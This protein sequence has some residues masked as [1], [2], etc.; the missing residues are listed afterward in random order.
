MLVAGVSSLQ[1]VCQQSVSLDAERRFATKLFAHLQ[2][3][4][5]AYHLE[6]HAGELIQ[7]LSRGSGATGT[8]ISTLWFSIIPTLFEAVVVGTVFWKVLGTPSIAITTVTSVALYLVYTVKMTN[9]R[10]EQ[11]RKVIESSETVGRIETES[12]VNY[13]TIVMFGKE[14]GEVERYGTVRKEYKNERVDMLGLFACIQLGQQSIRLA[15]T[16]IGL[17]LAGRAAVYGAGGGG[18]DFLSAGS[19]VVVQLYIQQLFTP[20]SI[21]GFMYRQLSEALT[22]L[23]KAI[24]VLKSK[25]IVMDAKGALDWDTALKQKQR[26]SSDKVAANNTNIGWFSA[27]RDENNPLRGGITFDNVTFKYQVVAPS[28]KLGGP[29]KRKEYVGKGFRGRGCAMW[30]GS[31]AGMGANFWIKSAKSSKESDGMNRKEDKKLDVGGIENVSFHIPAGKTA[32]LVGPSE[33]ANA[34]RRFVN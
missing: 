1:N 34:F 20:L 3:L 25:P 10:L 17:W 24:D 28:K 11:R 5:A 6:R 31:G 9:T 23:E 32:A 27:K 33:C 12:L 16:C 22:D 14:G 29:D 21:L 13:E 19:F 15:G 30:S 2:V 26:E 4:G 18:G 7:V 8:I